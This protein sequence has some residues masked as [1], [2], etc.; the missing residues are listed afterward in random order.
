VQSSD[1]FLGVCHPFNVVFS[2]ILI[3]LGHR[4]LQSKALAKDDLRGLNIAKS[5]VQPR[6]IIFIFIQEQFPW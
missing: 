5:V 3:S 6:I 2:F 4:E 1:C